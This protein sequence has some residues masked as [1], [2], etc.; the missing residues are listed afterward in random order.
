MKIGIIGVGRLGLA[1]GLNL[2]KVGHEV[3]G[4]DKNFEYIH[5]LNT[6]TFTCSEPG[7][8]EGILEA[9]NL[10]FTT[11]LDKIIDCN[12]IF[13]VVHTPSLPDNKYDHSNIDFV[14]QEIKKFGLQSQRKDLVI[15]CTTFPGYCE[16]ISKELSDLNYV[17]SYNPEFIAQGSIMKDQV[18]CDNVLIGCNDEFSADLIKSVY[19]SFVKSTPV[20][21]IMTCTEA[22]LTKLS[23]NCFLTTKI[24]FANMIG[25]IALKYKSDPNIVLRA[26]GSDSRIGNKYLGYGFGFGGPCFPRDNRALA[27]CASDVGITAEI[28]LATDKMNQLHL[29]YQIDHFIKQ[30]ADKNIPINFEFLTYKKDSTII[31]ESQQLKFALKLKELG[32]KITISDNRKEVLEQIIPLLDS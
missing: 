9:S 29:E 5:K 32:Y 2:A 31:E 23:I 11:T 8:N 14:I 22:E 6:K 4:M 19:Q 24:S 20:Y 1:F 27:K 28:S 16:S 13:V 21:N 17:V 15:N 26:I 7:I 25:D 18:Y 12:L 30:N 3:Y 10:Y